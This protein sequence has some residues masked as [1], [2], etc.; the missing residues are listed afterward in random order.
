MPIS[1]CSV[2]TKPVLCAIKHFKC[3]CSIANTRLNCFSCVPRPDPSSLGLFDPKSP[4]Y[5][6]RN[7]NFLIPYLPLLLLVIEVSSVIFN[8]VNIRIPSFLSNP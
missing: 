7:P 2:F 8:S 3:Y 5:V 4:S 6:S 1:M